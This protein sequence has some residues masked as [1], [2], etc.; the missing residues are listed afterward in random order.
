MNNEYINI[1]T[2]GDRA[3]YISICALLNSIIVNHKGNSLRIYIVCESAA[4]LN[5]LINKHCY[6]ETLN[7]ETRQDME[8]NTNIKLIEPPTG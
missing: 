8:S 1:V 6:V 4:E 5:K 7:V 3:T 2:A